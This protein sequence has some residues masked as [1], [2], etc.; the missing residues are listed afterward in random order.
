M[1]TMNS[2]WNETK[3]SKASVSALPSHRK[4]VMAPAT[5]Q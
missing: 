5:P 2:T 4:T 3:M 1:M